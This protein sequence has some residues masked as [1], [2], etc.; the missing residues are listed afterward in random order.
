M[1]DVRSIIALAAL[2]LA[3]VCCQKPEQS[4][5][6]NPGGKTPVL[7][8]VSIKTDLKSATATTVVL[9]TVINLGDAA[10]IPLNV[11]LRYSLSESMSGDD[12]KTVKLNSGSADVKL[13]GALKAVF[14]QALFPKK[15]VKIPCFRQG[16]FPTFGGY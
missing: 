8:S 9:S 4:G 1:K 5:G 15:S 11:Y 14:C 3:V 2:V 10:S 6:D 12:V 13:S 16:I 7:E